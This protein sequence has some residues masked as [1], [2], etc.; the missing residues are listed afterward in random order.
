MT[1]RMQA[2]LDEK[3]QTLAEV[4]ARVAALKKKYDDSVTQQAKIEADINLTRV[5]LERAEKLGMRRHCT[6]SLSLLSV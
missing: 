1:Q 2:V 5:R 4:N 6:T 3:R